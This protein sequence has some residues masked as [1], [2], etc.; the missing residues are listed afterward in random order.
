MYIVLRIKD[1]GILLKARKYLLR[2]RCWFREFDE[3]KYQVD[4]TAKQ[5]ANRIH[6]S[7]GG[8][9]NP[10]AAWKTCAS[11]KGTGQV[12][13]TS[14]IAGT[15]ANKRMLDSIACPRWCEMYE[16]TSVEAAVF[17]AEQVACE[18]DRRASELRR[19]IQ[20][21]QETDLQ[22]REAIKTGGVFR[23]RDGQYVVTTDER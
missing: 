3:P 17:V 8:T 13:C 12:G 14:T 7:G 23:Y 6:P 4:V 16:P 2:L 20:F 1:A 22:Y 9:V 18:H 5:R 19:Q 11:Y 10:P 15:C 21:L